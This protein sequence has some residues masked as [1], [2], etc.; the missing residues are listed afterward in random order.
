M[1]L[2]PVL[3]KRNCLRRRVLTSSSVIRVMKIWMPPP[4][5]TSA[6]GVA[7]GLIMAIKRIPWIDNDIHECE[8]GNGKER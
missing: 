2:E 3:D 8:D 4:W 5:A 7:I 1:I 6:L